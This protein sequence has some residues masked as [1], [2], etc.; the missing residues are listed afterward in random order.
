MTAPRCSEAWAKQGAVP[1][2]M[3]PEEFA[4][5]LHEDIEKWARIVKISGAKPDRVTSRPVELRLLS[6]GAAKGLVAAL[7][8]GVRRRRGAGID[9][10]FG[11]VGAMREKLLAGE[12]CDVVILTRA[13]IDE[14]AAPGRVAPARAARPWDACA[15]SIAVRERDALPDIARPRDALAAA[16]LAADA[17][18]FPDPQG[19]RRHPFPVRARAPRHSRARRGASAIFPDGATRCAPWPKPDGHAIGC[20]Q[21]TEILDTQGVLLVGPLPAEFELAT[22]YVA[23]VARNAADA[24]RAAQLVALLSGAGAARLRA[25]GGFEP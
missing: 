14:L 8:A 19:H 2:T 3:T 4:R 21:A 25:S 6:A 5:Y 22:V 18:Y 11:A 16:L 10:T 17:I 12:A 1:M 23:A 7:Q 13:Q 9:G 24:D 15:T 20:T